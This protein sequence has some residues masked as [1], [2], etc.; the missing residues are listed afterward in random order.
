YALT[1]T[2]HVNLLSE[3][4]GTGSDGK[5]VYLRD[6]WPSASEIRGIIDRFLEAEMFAKDYA[7]VFSGDERWRSLPVP[8]GH[9]FTWDARSTYVRRPPYFD[10]I[11][12]DPPPLSDVTGARVLVML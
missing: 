5:P 9:A 10:G 6:V 11:G 2:L 3:P 4:L 8:E 7:D 12:Q 1:G